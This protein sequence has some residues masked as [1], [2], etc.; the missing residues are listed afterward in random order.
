MHI[1]AALRADAM[2]HDRRFGNAAA[3]HRT[4]T[5]LAAA[6]CGAKIPSRE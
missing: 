6:T 2:P 3:F 5:P 4:F 1:A